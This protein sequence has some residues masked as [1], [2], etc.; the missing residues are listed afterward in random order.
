VGSQCVSPIRGLAMRG[1]RL[2]NCGNPAEGA[3]GTATSCGFVTIGLSAQ[4]EEGNAISVRTA[5]GSLCVNEPA[6]R[7]LSRYDVTIDFCTVD[8]ELFELIA[9]HRLILDWKGDSVG[10]AVDE[11]LNCE[12]GFGLEVWSQVSGNTCVPGQ[13]QSYYYWLLPWVSNG[14]IGGDITIEDGPVTFGFSG[15]T[16]KNPNWGRGPYDVVATDADGTPGR[17]DAPGVKPTE[18]LY[19]RT[20]EVSPPECVC[21]AIDLTIEDAVIPATVD[22]TEAA[23]TAALENLGFAVLVIEECSD[24][25]EAGDAIRTLPAVTESANVGST[26]YL[27]VSTGDC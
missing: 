10:H 1:T 13:T 27:Y 26:V 9:G 21:G 14:I 23:A 2:D 15:S 17:L 18:H 16:K 20:V 6:C 22:T 11:E 3:D 5:S 12:G 24:T 8:P 25:V 19:A 7:S 4:I